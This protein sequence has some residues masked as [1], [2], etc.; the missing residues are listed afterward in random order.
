MLCQRPTLR[1]AA[2]QLIVLSC[3]EQVGSY[4]ATSQA[5]DHFVQWLH[6]LYR[7]AAECLAYSLPLLRTF[8]KTNCWLRRW[9]KLIVV[10]IQCLI[11]VVNYQISESLNYTSIYNSRIMFGFVEKTRRPDGNRRLAGFIV[12]VFCWIN[13][14]NAAAFGEYNRP[15]T[16]LDMQI[17]NISLRLETDE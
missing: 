10:L 4:R 14:S 6:V 8:R 7:K 16:R 11:Y 9:R 17:F 13:F 15:T 5:Q 3:I 1:R 12:N 2:S